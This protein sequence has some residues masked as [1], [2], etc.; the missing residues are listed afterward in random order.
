M[1]GFVFNTPFYT[2]IDWHTGKLILSR[3]GQTKGMGSPGT[4]KFDRRVTFAQAGL[5]AKEIK[6]TT[7]FRGK[8]LGN[9]A[10]A[11]RANSLAHQSFGGAQAKEQARK[12]KIIATERQL[13]RLAPL[14]GQGRGFVSANEFREYEEY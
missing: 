5:A 4:R 2:K 9:N 11:I 12:E 14:V 10:M 7:N 6:G 1:Q 13:S 3:N 8:R